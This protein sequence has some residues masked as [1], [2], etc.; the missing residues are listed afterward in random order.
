[1]IVDAT[2]ADRG[3]FARTFDACVIGTG[4]AG[5]TLARRLAARGFS[6]ALMEGGGLELSDESQDLYKGEIVGLDYFPLDEA[7]LRYFGGSSNHWGGRCR[8]LDAVNFLPLAANPL[9]GWP[10]DKAALD[11][12]AAE[13]DEIL[14]MISAAEAP[15]LPLEQETPRFHRIQ[16]RYSPPTRFGEKY[17]DEIAASPQIVCALNANLVDMRLDDGLGTVTGAVFKSFEDGDP[18][19]TV[20][21]R[22]YVLALGG[23]ETPR[24]LLNFTSQKPNGIGNDNDVVGRYF[25]EHPHFRLGQV[26]YDQ[27]IPEAQILA[28]PEEAYAPTDA[29]LAEHGTLGFSLL[30]TPMIEDPLRLS[31]ELVRSAGCVTSFSEHVLEKVLGKNL[32]CERGGLRMYLAQ[33]G[34]RHAVQGTVAIHAEQGL[35]PE[36]RVMLADETDRFGLRRI[37]FDWRLTDLDFHTM[38]T[39]IAELGAH[40]AEQG[41]GRVQILDWLTAEPVR[42]PGLGQGSRVGGHHHMCATRMSA[43]PREGVVDADCRVHGVSNLYIGGSSAFATTGYANPTYTIVQL[44]LRLGDHLTDTLKA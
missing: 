9:S 29:F 35:H 32:D 5:I 10:I 26:Y 14:D 6:V 11:P 37:A 30:V 2:D 4:P 40:Y 41:T 27:P 21:A 25:C 3:L 44:A 19:F 8:A 20:A 23:L 34:K 16:Y 43:S 31:T 28:D 38:E 7:R 33:D 42:V 24:A 17:H 39:A 36:S 13:T 15:D 12:Y 22:T 18:G 1:M